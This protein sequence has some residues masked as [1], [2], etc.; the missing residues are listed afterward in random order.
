MW[1][2]INQKCPL[3]RKKI[4]KTIFEKDII[5]SNIID[6]LE[7]SCPKKGCKWQNRYEMLAEH[8]RICRQNEKIEKNPEKIEK[9][10]SK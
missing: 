2:N 10:C 6:E 5:S 9:N 8:L 7:C 3:C 4:K 1:T